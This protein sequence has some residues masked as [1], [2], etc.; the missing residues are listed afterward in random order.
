MTIKYCLDS[1]CNQTDPPDEIIVVDDCSTD[2]TVEV[3]NGYSRSHPSVRCVV[4]E[5]NSGAQ[6]ARNRGIKEATGEWIAFQDSDDE[7]MPEKIVKQI[8][9]L[10]RIDFDPMTVVHTDCFRFDH[11]TS[12]KSLWSL[13]RVDGKMVSPKLLSV[14]GPMFQ[15]MLTSKAALEKIGLLDEGVPS[16]Q[17]WDTSIQLAKQCR[18]IHL[19]EPL[20]VYH[21]HTADTI[22]KNREKDVEG[23][24][25]VIDKHRQEILDLCGANALNGHLENNAL[26]AIRW[27]L[28]EDAGKILAKSIGVTARGRRLKFLAR[29]KINPRWYELVARV[30]ARIKRM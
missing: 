22:S 14:A 11:A 3:V 2:A 24:Q 16:Y 7:W 10:E 21:L 25:Y 6:A 17:E 4:L 15:G 13:P 19:R 12:I 5:R 18:F 23:Y 20:F 27:G 29:H 30:A 26:K 28:Y 9:A 8:A 1:V